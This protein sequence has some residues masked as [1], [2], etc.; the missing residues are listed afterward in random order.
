MKLTANKTP[1]SSTV[2]GGLTLCDETGRARFMVLLC[3]TTEGIT[4][5]ENDAIAACLADAVNAAPI[6]VAPR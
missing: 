3:G 6:E 4:K 5:G 1:Y 2:G